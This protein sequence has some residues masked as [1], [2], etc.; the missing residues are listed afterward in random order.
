MDKQVIETSMSPDILIEE[1]GGSLQVRGWDE[2]KVVARAHADDLSIEEQDDAVQLSCQGECS[3]RV[4]ASALVQI[5]K[6]GGSAN[7]RGL[8]DQLRIG[9]VMGSLSLRGVS[10]VD[11]ERVMGEL[12]AKSLAGNLTLGAVYGNAYVRNV[13]G[14]CVVE[15]VKGNLDVR[16]VDG[17]VQAAVQGNARLRLEVL[18]GDSYRIE[19]SGNVHCRIPEDVN[20][21]LKLESG[22]QV[23][24]LILPEGSQTVTDPTYELTLGN[25]S[26]EMQLSAGG[27]LYLVSEGGWQ[28]DEFDYAEDMG[29]LNEEFA[30]QIAAQI[31]AQV[32]TQIEALTHQISAQVGAMAE[33]AGKSGL[34]EEQTERIMEQAREVSEREITRAQEKMRRNQEKLERKLEAAQRKQR[35][36][37][38]AAEQRARRQE[39]HHMRIHLG[40]DQPEK[41]AVSEEERLSILRMLEQKKISLE[42]AEQLLAALE[43]S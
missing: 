11:A 20:L 28:D 6:V 26:V 30:Q 32:Q 17:A 4:P 25:G 5:E 31:E 42:E 3:L 15:E 10:A 33:K 1:I 43:G 8:D 7:L 21:T 29:P 38:Q 36:K 24:K 14:S 39:K 9:D 19:A 23:M 34:S 41:E 2:A 16:G 40:T 12:S 18:D 22:A 37:V 35:L 27:T 13:Q